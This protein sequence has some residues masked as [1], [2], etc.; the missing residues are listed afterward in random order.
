MA[1]LFQLLAIF[2]VYS[3]LIFEK[4]S[5]AKTLDEHYKTHYYKR[6]LH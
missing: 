6:A 5:Y 4:K 3:S 1:Y 2:V